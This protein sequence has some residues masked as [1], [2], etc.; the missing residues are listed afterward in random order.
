MRR[1]FWGATVIVF[2]VW[3]SVAFATGRRVPTVSTTCSLARRRWR[4]RTDA[5]AMIYFAGLV[6]HVFRH[7]IDV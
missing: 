4:R 3:E 5:V 7:Q 6:Y 2:G 1:N